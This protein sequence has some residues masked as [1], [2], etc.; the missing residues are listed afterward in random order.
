MTGEPSS[1]KRLSAFR[2]VLLIAVGIATFGALTLPEAL[3]PSALALQAGDVA[4]RDFTAPRDITFES[5]VFTAQRKQAAA[6]AVL[7][8]YT[9]S[10][11]AISRQ[12][13]TR[14]RA[15]LD[16]ILIIRVDAALTAEQKRAKLASISE[17][18]LSPEDIPTILSLSGDRWETLRAEALSVLE[19]TMRGVI[20]ESDVDTAR[21]AVPSLV[22]FSF[23]ESEVGL[24]SDLVR[25]FAAANSYYSPELT[26]AAR[27][28]AR[29]AVQP[30]QRAFKTGQVILRAGEVVTDAHLEALASL[31]LVRMGVQ[32]LQLLGK[33]ALI[34][35][36][37]IFTGLYF[38]RRKRLGLLYNARSLLM[39]AAVYLVFLI[40]A[41]FAIP[42]NVLLPY[43]YPLPAVGMLLAT[44]FGIEAGIVISIITGILAAYGFNSDLLPYYL[45]TSLCG[46]LVLGPA[47]RFWDYLWA[48]VAVT[49]AGAAMLVAFRFNAGGLDWLGVAQLLLAAAGCGFL[50]AA[51]ALLGQYFLAQTLG[52]VTPLHLLEISRPDF[53]LLQ[54]LLR[55]APG[56]YQ[57][58]LQ[59]ANLAEQAAEA[60]GA[61]PLLTRVG[62]IFHDMG[63][64]K[65]AAFFI[66]NQAP[67]Q[68]NTH[69]DMDPAEAAATIIRHV[70][71]GVALARKYR[72]PR[73][74][75]DFVL[76]H[77]GSM[78]TRYQYNQALERAGGDASAV[79]VEKFRYPGPSPRSRETAILMLADGA[80]ARTR[81]Q[82]PR[83]EEEIRALI[84]GVVDYVQKEG[85]LD[86]TTL[87]LRDINLII[88]SFVATLRG[89]YHPRIQYPA[90][91][92]APAASES[93]ATTPRK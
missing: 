26:E 86:N 28:A 93:L 81:A 78:L 14:L 35:M 20:R 27:Q 41:R 13:I 66:E 2:I 69:Q 22:S 88:E 61:D 84:R 85:Q 48:G 73:R 11:P 23:S 55:N 1:S 12:Q 15:T 6:D 57:H 75:E 18:Q 45:F 52:L 19:R 83:T 40:G 60:I 56:T 47:R 65:N 71:D 25:P 74:L 34:V 7:P 89:A 5:A 39:V 31:G 53:P 72:L 43:L 32:P 70:T 92:P 33:G 36:T 4:P 38:Y 17:L 59:V 9:L 82:S 44:L 67:G 21:R 54:L 62:A 87:T 8:V 77:H 46:V 76:E 29:D 68:E 37:A 3:R 80:E 91:E 24:I 10:D 50:S 49:G 30:V 63:K 64:A 16:S 51:F 79:D 42:N 58:S 90:A